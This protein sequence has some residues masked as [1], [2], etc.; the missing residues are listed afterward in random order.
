[1]QESGTHTVYVVRAS[2]FPI[3]Y[4]SECERVRA[5]EEKEPAAAPP[6]KII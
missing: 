4:D 5:E 2:D 6:E 1:M 3:D